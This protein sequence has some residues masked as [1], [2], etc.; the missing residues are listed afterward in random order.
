MLLPSISK[1]CC[2][3]PTLIYIYKYNLVKF[4]KTQIHRD[5]KPENFVVGS[6]ENYIKVYVIDFGLAKYYRDN[7]GKHIPMQ[8][9]KGMIGTARYASISAHIG[10]E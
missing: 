10:K 8:D 4:S 7:L 6:G 1:I 2:R 9:K 3:S 5:I